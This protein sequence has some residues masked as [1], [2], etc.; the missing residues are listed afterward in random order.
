MPEPTKPTK[1]KSTAPKER[2]TVA[3]LQRADKTLK[4]RLSKRQGTW[5]VAT[6]SK[7][8]KDKPLR[9]TPEK[10]SSPALA[11]DRFEKVVA[12]AM[13]AGWAPKLPKTRTYDFAAA[14]DLLTAK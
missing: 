1:K 6:Q 8:G 10:F 12:R 13:E 4:V 9:A 7:T 5:V 11:K 2:P 14:E 3:T